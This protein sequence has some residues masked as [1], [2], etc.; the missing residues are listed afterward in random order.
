MT[1]LA[2]FQALLHR[3]S[4]QEDILVG[5]PSAGRDCVETEGLIGFFVNT[6][7]L[8]G[9]LSGNPSFHT[10]LQRT[11]E[12]AL[13]AFAHQEIPFEKLVEEMKPARDMSRSP[14]CQATFVLQNT[15]ATEMRLPGLS[16]TRVEVEDGTSQFDLTLELQETA[17]GIHGQLRY[18]TDLFDEARMQRM[19]AH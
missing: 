8:R 11:R 6:L 9:D 17:A 14:L 7:V 16:V 4:G 5:S 10:L 15:P 2:A 19:V 1:L 3:Y 18:L 13:S 12:A